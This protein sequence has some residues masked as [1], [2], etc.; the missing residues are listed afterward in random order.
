MLRAIAFL[1]CALVVG[2]WESSKDAYLKDQ[3]DLAKCQA[4]HHY[5]RYDIGGYLDCVHTEQA[6]RG[7]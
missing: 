5:G 1:A 4:Q 7:Y 2:C 6:K 3:I